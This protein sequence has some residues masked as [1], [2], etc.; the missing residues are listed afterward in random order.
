MTRNSQLPSCLPIASKRNVKAYDL[1][2]E[3][4]VFT[5]IVRY[6]SCPAQRLYQTVARA[7]PKISLEYAVEGETIPRHV[8]AEFDRYQRCGILDYGFVRLYCKACDAERLVG[9]SCKGR[10]FCPSCG[11]RR[12]DQTAERL[13]GD[14]WPVAN[15]RQWVLS[16]PHQVRYW[17]SRDTALFTDVMSAVTGVIANFYENY[18]LSCEEHAKV[19]APSAGAV[20]FVQLFGSSLVPV[21]TT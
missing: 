20:S 12:R 17:L 15:A 13:V 3:F 8:E 9:F 6:M 11:A 4:F 5:E 1:P 19:Y 7:W 16:F 18:T 2:P 14:V 21:L 10:S